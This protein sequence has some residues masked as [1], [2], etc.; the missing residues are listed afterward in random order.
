MLHPLATGVWEALDDLYLPG[1]LHFPLRMVVVRLEDGSLWLHSPIAIDDALAA[2][3]AALGPVSHIVAPSKLHHF[4]VAA[5]AARF[6]DATV[7]APPG[8]REKVAALP[9]GPTLGQTPAP[10]RGELALFPLDGIPWMNEVMFL[11]R[12]SGTALATDVFFHMVEPANWGSRLVFRLLGVL[13]HPRQSPLV[14]LQTRDRAAAGRSLARLLSHQPA[15]F[16]VAHGPPVDRDVVETVRAA[17]RWMLA[18]APA[19]ALPG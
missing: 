1:G 5:A 8:L 18:G 13:G 3:L 15:R 17:C 16:V 7:W 10:W 19:R 6:P 9:A 12:P 4:F 2:R 14:R 11:H